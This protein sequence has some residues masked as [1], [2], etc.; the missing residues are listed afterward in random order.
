MSN[1]A[2]Y[3]IGR[4]IYKAAHYTANGMHRD[5]AEWAWQFCYLANKP[6]FTKGGTYDV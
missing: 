4:A 6:L 2:W 1:H 5:A 3:R